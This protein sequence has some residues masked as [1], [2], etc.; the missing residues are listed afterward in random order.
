MMA[1]LADNDPAGVAS[2]SIVGA[3]AGYSQLWLIVLATFMV[4]AVQVSSARLGDVTQ[5]GVLHLARARYGWKIG[6]AVAVAG[7]I[8]N[9]ATLI[10]DVAALGASLEL[11]TGLPWRWF[12]IPASI[13][14]WLMTV[15][16]SFRA[17]RIFFFA[18]GLLLLSYVVTAFLV[19]PDWGEALRQ[20]FIPSVPRNVDE[21]K[22]AVALLGTTV[23]P[24]L[25]FWEAEGERE[26]HRT[27]RQFAQA[28]VDVT[29]GYVTSNVVSY[30]II[31][32]TAATLFVH[33][34]SIQTA[35]DAA[36]ALRPL[37]GPF[38]E[39]IFAAGLLGTGMLAVPMFAISS[40]YIACEVLGWRSG[41]S[42]QPSEAPGFYG[43]LTAAFLSGSVAVFLGVDP[44][45]ALLDSQILDGFL[46]PILIIVLFMLVNDRRL[47]DGERPAR[48]YNVWL[49]VAALVMVGG[50]SLLVL[51][52]I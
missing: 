30:F 10:A 35:A 13:L 17:L 20:T 50:A 33:H 29:T 45:V 42:R 22:A 12:V 36:A 52:L 24:Y 39:E 19:H 43:V 38:A 21:A 9:E 44:I 8:A 18:I 46:M 23:S 28:E 7:L 47:M 51:N 49:I 37:A 25:L 4:Q 27:R 5:Q 16:F 31:V 41:L 11:L 14:L 48:Y 6:M 32:T 2:Y 26:A 15:F 1:G 34:L 3:V 40:G